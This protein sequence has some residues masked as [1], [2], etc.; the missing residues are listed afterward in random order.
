MIYLIFGSQTPTIKSRIKKICKES[1]DFADD[2]NLVKF[3][4]NRVLVQDVI[5]EANYL[6]L[7]YD[8][9]VI[10]LENCYFLLKPRPR[11]KI[12]SEQDYNLLFKYIDNPNESCD[13]IFTVVSST[14]DDKS[15]LVK[16]LKEKAKVLEIIDP[17]KE[18]WLSYVKKYVR[19]TLNTKIDDDAIKEL[20]DRTNSDVALFQNNALKLS[21]Y[22]DHITY[23][24]VCDMVTRPLEENAFQ[25]FNHLLSKKNDEALKIYKDLRVGNVEPITLIS[26][27]SNQFRLLSQISY[28][29]KEGFNND[30]IASTLK[31]KPVR[32][33]ILKRQVNVIS[34]KR[35]NEVLEELF[36]LDYK[37]KSG[38]VDRFYI[39]EIFLI[40]FKVN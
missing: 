26:M 21:L 18:Q 12:E 23:Y 4:G 31:I 13:L 27:L 29:S 6:P 30:E 14:L 5:E 36:N 19:E 15:D 34:P 11:N 2:M 38:F 17:T 9:K 1:L 22:T 8:H 16:K 24:D 25:I 33:Q 10:V 28:L 40:N 3:D 7:G 37:I 39:F 20:A 32:V 35:L